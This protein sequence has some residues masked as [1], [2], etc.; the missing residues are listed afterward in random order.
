MR[1]DL[2]DDRYGRMWHL[3][4][5]LAKKG[6][7]VEGACVGYAGS[8]GQRDQLRESFSS[9][10]ELRLSAVRTPIYNGLSWF[11]LHRQLKETVARFRPDLIYAF[12]DALHIVLGALLS[13]G[14]GLPFAAD[15]Y[16][17]Y[18]A[19]GAT[20][21]PGVRSALAWATKRADFVTCVSDPLRQFLVEKYG[22]RASSILVI[23]NGVH[24]D[25]FSPTDKADARTKLGLPPA[26]KLIGTAGALSSSRDTDSLL[27]AFFQLAQTTP[28]L[29]LV[30][31]GKCELRLPQHERIHY[32]GDLD[33][34]RIP[35]LFR[36]LDVG[37]VGVKDDAFGRYCFPQKAAEMAASKLPIVIADVGVMASSAA[38]AWGRRYETGDMLSLTQAISS[39][40]GEPARPNWT[41]RTWEELA[42]ILATELTKLV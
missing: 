8:P 4:L 19:Y 6:M 23:E 7:S 35:I 16:D 34:S 30:L 10:G 1:R 3:P 17:N 25:F 21:F 33:H 12:S 29:R 2:L 39:Q 31:A 5:G 18:E 36:A 9:G 28:D 24:P 22:P 13:R 37:V 32:L 20:R 38:D 14:T 41:P 11:R 27:E 26:A 15:F 40:L 42:D